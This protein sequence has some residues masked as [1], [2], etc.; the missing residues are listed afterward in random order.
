VNSHD[1]WTVSHDNQPA[2]TVTLTRPRTRFEVAKA[3]LRATLTP[4]VITVAVLLVL[5]A[6]FDAPDW[7]LAVIAVIG[8]GVVLRFGWR[9]HRIREEW[10]P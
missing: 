10:R 9:D 7:A 2:T 6:F 8:A 4:M 1:E 5:G 3:V